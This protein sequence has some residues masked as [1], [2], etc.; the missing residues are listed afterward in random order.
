VIKKGRI[1]TYAGGSRNGRELLRPR[2]SHLSLK[3]HR[4]DYQAGNVTPEQNQRRLGKE[5]QGRAKL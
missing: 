2:S 5:T 3:Q 1:A 4:R